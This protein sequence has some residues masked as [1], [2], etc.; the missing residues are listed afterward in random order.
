[1]TTKASRFKKIMIQIEKNVVR[2]GINIH[3]AKH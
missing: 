3:K 2:K 1:M